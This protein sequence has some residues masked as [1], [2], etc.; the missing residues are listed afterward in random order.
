M[1][2]ERRKYEHVIN[3][4]KQESQYKISNWLEYVMLINNPL[5]EIDYYKIDTKTKLFNRV[6]NYPIYISGM[7]GGYQEAER[8]NSK[9]ADLAYKYNI[10][11]GLGSIR[12]MLKNPSLKYTYDVKKARDIFLI[13][14]IGGVQLKEYSISQ[15]I[16]AV[17]S[18]EADAIA[19]HLNPAQ[20]LIQGGDLNWEGVR[21]KIIELA[22][23]L[24]VI[25]KEVG[26]G[27][28]YR[29]IDNL[30]HSKVLYYD[31]AGAGG[32][33]WTRIEYMRNPNAVPGFQDWGIPTALALLMNKKEVKLLASGGIRDGIDGYKC[34]VLGAE[35]F[36]MA[37][38]FLEAVI[39]EDYRLIDIVI[40]QLK[41]AMFLTGVDQL[42]KLHK[43]DYLLLDP[44]RYSYEQIRTSILK[45]Q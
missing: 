7:T 26:A 11:L 44:L 8:I 35:M 22:D 40:S 5:P 9:L 1:D 6:F 33:S 18:I 45:R 32:T 23:N 34:L 3:S 20:E 17:N 30:K 39:K 19:I 37:R 28:S 14:N 31:V 25:V 15:I 13:A 21:D 2:I 12:A 24:N 29:V 42:D 27:L 43:V 4:L 36:G 41:G 16:D 38:P 10:P